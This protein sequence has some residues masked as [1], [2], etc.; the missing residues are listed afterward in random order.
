[1]EGE[2]EREGGEGEK[3]RESE[4]DALETDARHGKAGSMG[5]A[6]SGA[7]LRCSFCFP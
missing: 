3:V 4:E 5:T 2:R 7:F 6:R 1:M